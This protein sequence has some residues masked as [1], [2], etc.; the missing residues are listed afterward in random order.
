[1][2]SGGELA[3]LEPAED[4]VGSD[5]RARGHARK[6]Q[7]RLRAV[8]GGDTGYVRAVEANAGEHT[9]S[10]RPG[11]GFLRL[12]VWTQRPRP[13]GEA[14]L[15]GDPVADEDVAGIDARVDHRDH[16]AGAI[17]APGPGLV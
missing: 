17:E 12:P 5:P 15:V 6:V 3:A 7:G 16:G 8:A 2:Y 14:P 11:A 13:R 1:M 4:G 10:A 9:D